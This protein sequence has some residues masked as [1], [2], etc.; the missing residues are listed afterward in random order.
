MYMT[1]QSFQNST[2]VIKKKKE[3]TIRGFLKQVIYTFMKKK[4]IQECFV[5]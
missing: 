4:E 5:I 3:K 2:E 1:L